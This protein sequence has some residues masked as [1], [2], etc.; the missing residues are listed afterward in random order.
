MREARHS[1][2]EGGTLHVRFD[3]F[4]LNE[5]DA[6]LMRA[7]APVALPPKAFSVLCALLHGEGRLVTKSALLDTVW[8]HQYVS[9]SELK[10]T[11]SEL[12]NAL[13]DDARSPRLIETA[14]RRG[15]RFIGQASPVQAAP[16]PSAASRPRTRPAPSVAA[17]DAA[18][19]I[20]RESATERLDAACAESDAGRRRLLCVAG[21]AGVGKTTVIDHV[22][23]GLDG[24]IVARGQCV[25]QYGTG[26]P[27]LSILEALGGLCRADA[28]LLPLLKSCAPTWL[29]QLPWLLAPA[30]RESLRGELA[31]ATQ[32]RMLREFA[33]LLERYTAD[34][35]LVLVTEDAHWSDDATV[36]LLDYVARRRAAARFLWV[37]SF[38]LAE[39]ASGEH[40]L[41]GVR[42]E[43]RGRRLCE[44]I[45]L[46]P[47]SE[48][49]LASYLSQRFPAAALDEG[50]IH[51]LHDRTSGLPL[52]VVNV[53]DEVV[54]RLGE[55][56][57][58][59]A[60]LEQAAGPEWAIPD[61]LA[62]AIGRQI[63][64]LPREATRAL[65]AASVCGAEFAVN[66]IAD[67]AG[68]EVAWAA[69]QLAALARQT[70]WIRPLAVERLA[71]GSLDARYG[72]HHALYREVFYQR[73]GQLDRA[74]LHRRVARSLETRRGAAASAAELAWHCECG[75]EPLAAL[76]HYVRAADHALG[77]FAPTEAEG[78]TT[79]AMALLPECPQTPER[80]ELELALMNRRAVA[81]SQ[82]HGVTSAQANE[83]FR[84]AA[85]ICDLLPQSAQRVAMLVGF[86]W[87]LSSRGDYAET[88]ALAAR[89]RSLSRRDDNRLMEAAGAVIASAAL[90]MEGH[91]EESL[92]A[93][94]EALALTE[95]VTD[96][97][98]HTALVID[99][100]VAAGAI[101]ALVGTYRGRLNRALKDAAHALERAEAIGQPMSRGLSLRL[102]GTAFARLDDVK[103]A[104]ECAVKMFP[105]VE[106][107]MLTVGEGPARWLLGWTEARLGEPAKGYARILEGYE[108]HQRHGTLCGCSFVLAFAA[109]AAMLNGQTEL[110]ARHI[111]EGLALA[112]RL[113]ERIFV[114]DLLLIR[115]RLEEQLGR[116]DDARESLVE[117]RSTAEEGGALIV[118]IA[119]QTV[120][121]E[122]NRGD[123]GERTTLRAALARLEGGD[124]LPLIE[125]ARRVASE[126]QSLRFSRP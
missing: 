38:R 108:R 91:L 27:Y 50:V 61:S 122:L 37:V 43:L 119:A 100:V 2:E 106:Q 101:G 23:A 113:K 69:E 73:I 88:R 118:S 85:D 90:G 24:A 58:S 11:V 31:V 107:H 63:A 15:Y 94:D 48:V 52:F 120:L 67:T 102:A 104:H 71:D 89:V 84:R 64:R 33:E 40:P 117:A 9:E 47:F 34:R 68:R 55:H 80:L 96:L 75:L 46:D 29:L 87:T 12:R 18:R 123:A 5:S 6:R 3:A 121:C 92:A 41:N 110:A 4:E 105:M 8:G 44:E 111:D 103:R 99:P 56:A 45:V 53:V 7:G 17:R 97:N 65:E 28:T 10:T 54:A 86:G 14:A 25:E 116:H 32:D 59:G 93:A 62:G 57:L 112:A 60:T 66:T 76:A 19:V 114:P 1:A 70:F 98:L 20:A 124:G 126:S 35:T 13:G 78:L 72:F 82:R 42:H 125:R 95:G 49:E 109:E 77:R 30:E 83:A 81:C 51:S 22:V 74:Q 26:E 79:R 21:E 115:G 39:L 16:A 36:R